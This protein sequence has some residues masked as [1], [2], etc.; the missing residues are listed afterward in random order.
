MSNAEAA[1]KGRPPLTGKTITLTLTIPRVISL[2]LFATVAIVWFFVMGLIIGRGYEP[3]K[4]I[5]ALAEIMPG[6]D[7]AAPPSVVHDGTAPVTKDGEQKEKAVQPA[8]KPTASQADAAKTRAIINEADKAHREQVKATAQKPPATPPKNEQGNK[9]PDKQTPKQ[10][11]FDYVYQAAS[12]KQADQAEALAKKLTAGGIPARV[13]AFTSGNT[14]W[15]RVLIPF[16]GTPDDT[17][18]L[19]KDLERFKIKKILLVSKKPSKQ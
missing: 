4:H 1:P 8:Q 7:T 6:K 3:E 19:R 17:E 13:N 9:E 16:R 5:P 15:H 12:F 11:R 14:K 2:L 18:T 10:E